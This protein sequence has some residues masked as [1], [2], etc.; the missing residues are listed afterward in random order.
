MARGSLTNLLA[1]LVEVSKNSLLPYNFL[2]T[3]LK[4]DFD[5]KI[6]EFQSPPAF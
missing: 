1:T 4:P 2:F 5:S 3:K 6:V